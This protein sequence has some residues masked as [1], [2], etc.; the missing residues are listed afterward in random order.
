[1]Q[2]FEIIYI[3]EICQILRYL[4][5]KHLSI[6]YS[7][8]SFINTGSLKIMVGQKLHLRAIKRHQIKF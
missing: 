7:N 5:V 6:K 8:V 2:S 1:M 4:F 3:F